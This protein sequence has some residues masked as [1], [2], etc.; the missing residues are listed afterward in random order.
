[1][2]DV[3]EV[4]DLLNARFDIVLDSPAQAEGVEV[5]RTLAGHGVCRQYGARSI[6]PALLKLICACGLSA[7]SK[8][9][10]QQVD[11]VRVADSGIREQIANLIPSMP[12]IREAPEFLVVCGNGRRLPQISELHGETFA[13]DHLDAFFNATFDAG[14]VLGNLIAAA[15]AAGLGV[16]PISVIRN[17]AQTVS[18]LLALPERVFPAVGLCVGWPDRPPRI[19]RRLPLELTLHEDRYDEG[20][21]AT[22][23]IEHDRHRGEHD[24]HDPDSS[25]FVGWSRQKAKMYAEPQRTDFGEFVRARGFSLD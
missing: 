18:D 23:I 4:I 8:S 21:W 9:D 19:A 11:I 10:L 22:T 3:S 5:L 16:C 12:W 17:H 15:D 14:I 25:D 24:G 7:P 1:M 13:N 2:V 20:D 6:D